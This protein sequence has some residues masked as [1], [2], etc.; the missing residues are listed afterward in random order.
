M[1]KFDIVNK[2]TRA[3]H[4]VKF[5]TKKHSPEIL[6]VTG[7]VGVVT[8]AVMACVAT[9]KLDTV[10]D[11]TKANLDMIHEGIETGE[12]ENGK[13]A[14]TMAYAHTGLELTKVYGPSV[15]LGAASIGCILASN[16][17]IRKRN[18][19]LAAAYTTIDNSFK[20]Y[21]SRVID[22]FGEELDR[23]LKLNLKTKEIEEI[24]VDDKGKEKKVKSKVEVTEYDGYSEFARFFDDGCNGWEKDSEWNHK[25][26][27]L[28]QELATKKLR[29]QGYLF[30]N[31]VYEMLGIP[32]TKAGFEV[33]WIYD[34]KNPIGDNYVDFGMY[35]VHNEKARDF[36]NGRERTILLDFNIDGPIIRHL[37]F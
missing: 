27:N 2:A 32:K 15:A 13:K 5:T 11:D 30:L 6:I 16:N 23:E 17:I 26:L 12:I 24:V 20:G 4:R 35:N 1:T 10:L 7:V 37:N 36:V 21:R 25:F 29:E 8:S 31:D 18:I 9:R 22:R 28:Q 33:G 19:A 34:E 3:F 14:L